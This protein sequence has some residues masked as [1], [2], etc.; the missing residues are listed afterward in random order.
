MVEVDLAERGVTGNRSVEVLEQFDQKGAL[1]SIS[2][3]VKTSAAAK[4]HDRRLNSFPPVVVSLERGA[5]KSRV[6]HVS[7]HTV[8]QRRLA[9]KRFVI[10]LPSAVI[11]IEP[12]SFLPFADFGIS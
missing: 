10:V 1:R 12:A 9:A 5:V 2:P 3:L 8:R 6:G 7:R 11:A 4:K